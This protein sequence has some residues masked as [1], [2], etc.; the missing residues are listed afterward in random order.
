VQLGYLRT[1]AVG[2]LHPDHATASCHRNRDHPAGLT[3][4]AVPHA[5]AEQLPVY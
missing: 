2:D 4:P 5:V 3:R 1:A